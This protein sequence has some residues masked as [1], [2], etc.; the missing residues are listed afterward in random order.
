MWVSDPD[1]QPPLAVEPRHYN[2][3]NPETSAAA[4]C[5]ALKILPASGVQLFPAPAPL[6]ETISSPATDTDLRSVVTGSRRP[7]AGGKTSTAN[8]WMWSYS[9]PP[10]APRGKKGRASRDSRLHG[11]CNIMFHRNETKNEKA[12][13]LCWSSAEAC[14]VSC[15]F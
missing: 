1:F 14:P 9:G 15:G 3:D 6:I 7:P 4:S 10:V 11:C 13:Q 5:K 12:V 8:L 2:N